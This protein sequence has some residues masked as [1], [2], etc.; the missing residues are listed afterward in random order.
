[1]VR[2]SALTFQTETLPRH[3]VELDTGQT[4]LRCRVVVGFF[5]RS[6]DDSSL[7][8]GVSLRRYPLVGYCLPI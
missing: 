8:G 2:I 1:V 7:V 6:S 5:N 3:C 4:C